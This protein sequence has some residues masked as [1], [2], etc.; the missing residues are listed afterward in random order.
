MRTTSVTSTVR[1][2]AA[3]LLPSCASHQTSKS[4]PKAAA[5]VPGV[6]RQAFQARFPAVKEVEWK[7][8]SDRNY[9]A[10]FTLKEV[11]IAAKF[12]SAGKWLET[13]TDA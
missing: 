1:W 12:D 10:E 11:E 6:V 5:E 9:E 3:C 13:S 8:K 2:L 7:L 4:K